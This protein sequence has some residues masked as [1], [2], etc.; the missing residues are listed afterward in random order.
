MKVLTLSSM[1]LPYTTVVKQVILQLL[2]GKSSQTVHREVSVFSQSI[3]GTVKLMMQG[4]LCLHHLSCIRLVE[5]LAHPKL[6]HKTTK[7]G[8]MHTLSKVDQLPGK[9][10]LSELQLKLKKTAVVVEAQESGRDPDK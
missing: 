5:R 9:E 2:K 4:C 6:W 1:L 7:K 8:Q 3:Y 10:P